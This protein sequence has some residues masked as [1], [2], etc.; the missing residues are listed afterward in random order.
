M[1]DARRETVTDAKRWKMMWEINYYM[2]GKRGQRVSPKF[3]G[4]L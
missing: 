1:L 4:M 2:K 3:E